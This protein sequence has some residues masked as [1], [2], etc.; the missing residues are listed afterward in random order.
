[1]LDEHFRIQGRQKWYE[2]IDEMQ[3]DLDTYLGHYN[4]ERTHQG[5]NM[6]GRTPYQA[7]VDGLPKKE[8]K[9][10]A[11]P[12]TPPRGYV[13]GDYY[14]CTLLLWGFKDALWKFEFSSEWI[15]LKGE[16][17]FH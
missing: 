14:L 3:Q 4:R 2:T 1:M 8:S 13:S 6:S 11:W 16:T 9:K 12:I 17:D 5:R 15:E 7:F 10:A